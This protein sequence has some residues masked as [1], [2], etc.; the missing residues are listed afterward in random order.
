MNNQKFIPQTLNFYLDIINIKEDYE[1]AV[2][3][4]EYP[5]SANNIIENLGPKTRRF[6]VSCQFNNYLNTENSGW[7]TS[8][9]IGFP[10]FDNLDSFINE[11]KKNQNSAF[12]VHPDYGELKGKISKIS[13]TRDDTQEYAAVT[14]DFIEQVT[15]SKIR[16]LYNVKY[17]GAAAFSATNDAT[18]GKMSETLRTTTYPIGWAANA[19]TNINTLDAWLADVTNPATSI[20]NSITY[21]NTVPGQYIKAI[22]KVVDRII[23]NNVEVRN[24]PAQY[25]NNIILGVSSLKAQFTG[26][27]AQYV[28]IM[29]ASRV[30]YETGVVYDDDENKALTIEKKAQTPSFDANGKFIGTKSFEVAMSI[31]ELE[32]TAYDVRALID[33]AIQLDRDNRDLLNIARD[34]QEFINETKLNRQSIET[35][36][37]VPFQSMHT[38]VTTNGLS[39]QAA[40]TILK[41]NPEIKNPTFIDGELKILV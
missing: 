9:S 30:A 11:F 13:V 12:F 19:N 23:K 24:I 2:V 5:Y 38:W 10:S 22:N 37:N 14:F 33:E 4:K 20:V 27:D 17:K 7:S 21:A 1:N 3:V 34:L 40:E 32:S 39:Y 6:D 16:P 8:G 28:H 41:L 29:G 18:V 31:N 25:I 15:S 26:I 36:E 35:K